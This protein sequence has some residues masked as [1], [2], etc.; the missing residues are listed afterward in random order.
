[1]IPRRFRLAKMALSHC[2]LT[3]NFAKCITTDRKIN[4][5]IK[6]IK[7]KCNKRYLLGYLGTP[8]SQQLLVMLSNNGY[9]ASATI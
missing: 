3:H 9:L 5:D 2:N 1:M 6:K 8:V 4:L 7:E